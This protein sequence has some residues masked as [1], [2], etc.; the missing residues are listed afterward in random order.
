MKPCAAVLVFAAALVLSGCRSVTPNAGKN[1]ADLAAEG[2]YDELWRMITRRPALI[3]QR[4]R[5]G[6][7]PLYYLVRDNQP[8][9]ATLFLFRGADVQFEPPHEVAG[10]ALP[11]IVHY[12][13]RNNMGVQ[14][15]SLLLVKLGPPYDMPSSNS[16]FAWD[17]GGAT[18][19]GPGYG[20][21]YL[22]FAAYH[23]DVNVIRYLMNFVSPLGKD[24][25]GR[26]PLFWA[27]KA[28]HL[29]A[30]RALMPR[31]EASLSTEARMD[32]L[33][34]CSL[35]VAPYLLGVFFSD[36]PAAMA[37]DGA[38]LMHYCA[39]SGFA[40]K[41]KLFA[42]FGVPLDSVDHEGRTPLE[43][44]KAQGNTDV[45]KALER[46]MA[47]RNTRRQQK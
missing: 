28:G 26:I 42:D 47:D 10:G 15:V 39:L 33:G 44:A 7:P 4:D 25:A 38:T 13:I 30:V 23:G 37:T 6:L 43:L 2:H 3:N 1:C 5:H 40:A 41:A 34:N 11:T 32:I 19:G 18:Y 8:G 20:A 12:A 29:E 46:L 22:H 16:V 21:T 35:A 17:Q 45:A 27:A 9:L 24:I 36:N 14:L 31:D